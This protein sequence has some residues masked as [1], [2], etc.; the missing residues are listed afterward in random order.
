MRQ[1]DIGTRVLFAAV[2]PATLIATVIAWYFTYV[3][4]GALDRE[5]H[6]HGY[7][8]ARQLAPACEYGVFSGNKEFL[9]QLADTA[10]REGGVNG[11]AVFD[12]TGA[13]LVRSGV[14]HDDDLKAPRPG[15]KVQMRESPPDALVF[16]APVGHTE[17]A[18]DDLLGME[19]KHASAPPAAIGS[20]LVQM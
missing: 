15:A 7:A 4:I 18:P 13:L 20:V 11:V 2:A 14:L 12:Q 1:W 10:V 9:Q 6:E 8:I 19:A 16:L 17:S 3:R 5:L